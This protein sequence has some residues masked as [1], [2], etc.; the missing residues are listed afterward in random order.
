MAERTGSPV[1][2]TLWSYVPF[3]S[4]KG[5]I[6]FLTHTVLGRFPPGCLEGGKGEESK[7]SIPGDVCKSGPGKYNGASIAV[8]VP[9]KTVSSVQCVSALSDV[10][11]KVD[12]GLG[13]MDRRCVD[14]V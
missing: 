7:R 5:T 14:K 1:L 11:S 2:H 6:R 4:M 3:R 13:K 9:L 12:V 8:F 10:G